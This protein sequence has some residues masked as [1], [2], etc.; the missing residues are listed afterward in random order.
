MPARI[1]V[2]DDEPSIIATMSPLLRSR[3]FIGLAAEQDGRPKEAAEIWRKL[4]EGASADAGWTGFV[5]ESL[6]RVDP[7][8]AAVSPPGP[9]ADDVAAAGQMSPEQRETMVRGMVGRLAERLKA[10][11]SD[12][13]GWLRLLRAYMVLGDREQAR[14]DYAYWGVNAVVLP[15]RISAAQYGVHYDSLRRTAIGPSNTKSTDTYSTIAS[16]RCR[17]SSEVVDRRSRPRTKEQPNGA[18][19]A[20]SKHRVHHARN[21]RVLRSRGLLPTASGAKVTSSLDGK[22]VLPHKIRWIA[23]PGLKS[24]RGMRP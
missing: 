11:G 7:G 19:S 17:A 14:Q 21:Q 22:T 23:H 2:V 6:A 10:D 16:T 18:Q 13:E 8:A 5:R 24:S 20:R 9:G 4:L 15:D 12:V 3:Y 1:L